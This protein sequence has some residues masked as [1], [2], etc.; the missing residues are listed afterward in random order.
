[1]RSFTGVNALSY[2]GVPYRQPEFIAPGGAF[3]PITINWAT[4]WALAGSPANLGVNINLSG[5]G[6]PTQQAIKRIVSVYIDNLGSN[7]PLYVSFPDSGFVVVAAP[8]TATWYPVVTNSF[9]LTVYA[10]GLATGQIPTTKIFVT[11]VFVPPYADIELPQALAKYLASAT[12]SKG[13]TIYNTDF[14]TPALGDQI[15]NVPIGA[16]ITAAIAAGTV[17]QDNLFGSPLASGFIYLTCLAFTLA[18]KSNSLSTN[19][20]NI[21]IQSAGVS[22]ILWTYNFLDRL[23]ANA[24]LQIT[25]PMQAKLDATQKWQ[26]VHENRS[27]VSGTMIFSSNVTL[28]YTTNPN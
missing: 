7:I 4:Y 22:G 15:Q 28:I 25:I 18:V 13:T 3:V 16:S 19:Q 10:L 2:I 9:N 5:S 20:Y 11:D 27:P 1:M 12:I 24:V 26:L 17:L 23:N 21:T 6:G 14:G 8:N